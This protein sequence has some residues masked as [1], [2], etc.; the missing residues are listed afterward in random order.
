MAVNP[1]SVK[2]KLMIGYQGWFRTPGDRNNSKWFH[3]FRN[4]A[5]TPENFTIDMWPDTREYNPAWLVNAGNLQTRGGAQAQVFSAT[6]P[7]VVCKHFDWMQRYNIDGAY[8]QRFVH[9]NNLN[10]PQTVLTNVRNAAEAT[11]RIWAVEY[12]VSSLTADESGYSLITRDW[13][14]LVNSFRVLESPQHAHQNGKPVVFIWGLPFKAF[15]GSTPPGQKTSRPKG[16]ATGRHFSR[17]RTG[18]LAR[19]A[20]RP[21]RCRSAQDAARPDR[22]RFRQDAA[23]S[24]TW[25][26]P[27]R[28]GPEGG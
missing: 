11:R 15:C 13:D 16:V 22:C 12:D 23:L 3:W 28:A 14:W 25:S 10:T 20:S 2:G 24:K 1:S 4:N 8:V 19:K 7:E 17:K 21:G 27:E 9:E 18:G 6:T 5:A 26:Q